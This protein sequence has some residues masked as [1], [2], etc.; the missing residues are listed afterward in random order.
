[1]KPRRPARLATMLALFLL[2]SG[3]YS[4]SG[5]AQTAAQPALSSPEQFFGFQ[6]GADRKLANWDRLLA[7]YQQLAEGVEPDEA[8]RVGQVERGP[9]VRRDL[10]FLAGQPRQAGSIQAGQRPA[11]RPARACRGRSAEARGRRPCRRHPV[12]CAAF[13]RGC[14]VADRR[15]VRLRQRHP[16]R[17]GSAADAGQR[18]QHRRAVDQSRRHADDRRLV[19]EVCRDAARGGRVAV[20]VP[21]VCRAR[22]QPRWLR[23]QPARVAAPGQAHV[24]RLDAAGVCRPSPD[25]QRQRAALHPAVRRADSPRCRSARLA[26]DGLV[27]RAHGQSPRGRG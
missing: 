5:T 6:M 22:Q 17:R 16:D 13:E 25:G 2:G 8:R 9:A 18:H 15:R 12:L 14:G 11:G 20:A 21:E 24:S 19:H 4:R 7:Y 26:R 23:A 10:H 3:A 27:G 1:M